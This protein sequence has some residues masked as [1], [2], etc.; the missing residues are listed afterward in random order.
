[1][2]SESSEKLKII[3]MGTPDFAVPALEALIRSGHDVVAV[4]SQPPRPKGRGHQV[5]LSPVHQCAAD[6]NI[7]VYTPKSLRKDLNAQADFMALEPDL[8]VVAAYGLLLPKIVLEAPRYGCVNIHASL[9]PRWRG[10]SPIQH[11][12]WAG[13]SESGVTIMQMEEGLDTGPMIEKKAL[14]IR[15]ETTAQ[16]LHDAL[17]AL[18]AAMIDEIVRRLAADG[19]AALAGEE[20][21]DDLATYAPLLNKSDGLVDWTQQAEQ[22]DRQIRALNPWPGVYTIVKDA[23]GNEKRLKMIEARPSVEHFPE[24]PGT[25]I[26]RTGHISCGGDTGLRVLTV[27]PENAK[28]MDFV[29]AVNGG[30]LAVGNVLSDQK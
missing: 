15:P 11:A 2:T 4:Y 8:A 1:M 22:I 20:Q 18:G 24:P 23:Q 30:Y 21:D 3:F 27:Q 25:I 9:L 6:H 17:S 16:S 7:P 28:K 29:A 10:A 26:D 19:K 5:Q 12:I 13:D 14:P